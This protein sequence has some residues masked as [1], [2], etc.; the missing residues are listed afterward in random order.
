MNKRGGRR[1]Q[2]GMANP[3]GPGSCPDPAP[4][5]RADA[6]PSPSGQGVAT[7]AS[8]AVMPVVMVLDGRIMSKK[9]RYRTGNGHFFLDKKTKEWIDLATLQILIQKAKIKA[10]L[11][12]QSTS[13]ITF[14]FTYSDRRRKDT[15]NSVQ[16]VADLLVK[17]GILADDCWAVLPYAELSGAYEKGVD[18]CVVEI[19][20]C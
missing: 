4:T 19:W 3:A 10:R 8:A 15:F 1:G 12:I 7:P 6:G 11:P 17:E 2:V 20:P 14:R 5:E 18:R 9:N 16:S 13:R